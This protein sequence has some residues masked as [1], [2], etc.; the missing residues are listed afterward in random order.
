[1][2]HFCH[3]IGDPSSGSVTILDTSF[4]HRDGDIEVMKGKWP[5]NLRAAMLE[6]GIGPTELAKKSGTFKQNVGRF[7]NGERQLTK[8][9]AIKF[10]PHL[11]KS[12][13]ELI[14]TMKSPISIAESDLT[15]DEMVHKLDLT[16]RSAPPK[17]KKR[18]RDLVKAVLKAS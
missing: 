13:D 14:F 7:C 1:M 3:Q 8:P 4:C 17:V 12:P 11:D 16:L 2:H 9:W 18:L 10:A 5:N 6:K 15:V